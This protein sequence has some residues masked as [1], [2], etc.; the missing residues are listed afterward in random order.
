MP[1]RLEP[2]VCSAHHGPVI[3][4]GRPL[5]SRYCHLVPK[6]ASEVEICC[7]WPSWGPSRHGHH[8]GV[9]RIL[10]GMKRSSF[11]APKV[12]GFNTALKEL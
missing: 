8:I 1:A 3:R 12:I 2:F 9:E 10:V 7:Q 5:L 11:A 6:S 4:H